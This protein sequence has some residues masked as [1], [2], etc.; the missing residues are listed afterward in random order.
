MVII[1]GWRCL[2]YFTF[3]GRITNRGKFK[4]RIRN[5]FHHRGHQIKVVFMGIRGGYFEI[6]FVILWNHFQKIWFFS[7]Y[8]REILVVKLNHILTL[9]L[10]LRIL[11][12]KLL[13]LTLNLNK[14]TNW[15]FLDQ[16][17]VKKRNLFWKFV[18]QKLKPYVLV[19]KINL[20]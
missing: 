20:I 19:W 18:Y 16:S 11:V 15:I 5:F 13:T 14:S 17:F 3:L 4:K 12:R 9:L 6:I 1:Y 2:K 7:Y 8:F 10:D